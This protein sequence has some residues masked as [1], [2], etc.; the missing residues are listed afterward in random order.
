MHKTLLFVLVFFSSIFAHSQKNALPNGQWRG[1][2]LRADGNDIVF[3]FLVKDSVGKKIL[4]IQNAGERL[5]VNDIRYL[6]DS[7]IINLPFFES[8]IRAFL[9]K[10]G[11]LNGVYLKRL[12]TNYQVMPFHA[13]KESFRFKVQNNVVSINVTG[14]WAVNFWDEVSKDSTFAIGEFIQTG[15]AVTGTF[16]NATGDYRYLQGVVEGDSLKLSCFDGGHAYLFTA[17]IKGEDSIYGFHF[18]GPVFKEIWF[19]KKDNQARLPDEFALTKM[20]PG[21]QQFDF[22]FRDIDGKITSIQDARYKNKVVVIQIMGSWCPNCMDETPV[23]SE[24]YD[25]YRNKGVEVIGLAYERST[26]FERSQKSLRSFQK[27]FNVHYDILITGVSVNDSLRT[28]KTLPQL[29]S[30]EGFPTT[31]F[32]DKKGEVAKIHT[33]FNGPGTGEH[34]SEQ[35]KEFYDLVNEL[36]VK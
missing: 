4:Y 13:L 26:D 36:L 30:I 28:Q 3:N 14:R 22:S 17:K 24:L 16:L 11:R 23:L 31:I 8:Q 12:A 5:L 20:K 32:I 21:K 35:K 25:S 15:N 19:G 10:T 9:D 34:F 33:G 1:L 7:I 6:N 2:L 29:Q 18:S 27:R